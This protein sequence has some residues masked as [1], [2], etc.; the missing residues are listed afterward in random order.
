MNTPKSRRAIVEI[1][2]LRAYAATKP[3]ASAAAFDHAIATVCGC[4]D[5]AIAMWRSSRKLP[6]KLL[7][8]PPHADEA[9]RLSA[10]AASPPQTMVSAFDAE[11][12]RRCR[13]SRGAIEAW[14]RSRGLAAK[15][16]TP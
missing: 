7:P 1:R 8:K 10:Y 13:C 15:V 16:V 3:C 12:A 4:T 11:I 14:R 9:K 5:A 2:R 6:A